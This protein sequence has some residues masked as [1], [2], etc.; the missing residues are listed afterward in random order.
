MGIFDILKAKGPNSEN[1]S[2]NSKYK[3][4]N[5]KAKDGSYQS[6]MAVIE[7]LIGDRDNN[8][9]EILLWIVQN[10][11]S[12]STDVRKLNE[13]A[14]AASALGKTGG[15]LALHALESVKDMPGLVSEVNHAIAEIREKQDS[16]A[17]FEGL[18]TT[19]VPTLTVL[20]EKK[21]ECGVEYA[22]KLLDSSDILTVVTAARYLGV[23][24]YQPA[25]D[26]LIRLVE[27]SEYIDIQHTAAVAL[28]RIGG[29]KAKA[30]LLSALNNKSEWA[31]AGAVKGLA[32][33]WADGERDVVEQIAGKRSGPICSRDSEDERKAQFD[34]INTMLLS[35]ATIPAVAISGAE[36]IEADKSRVTYK[37]KCEACGYVSPNQRTT[38]VPCRGKMMAYFHCPQCKSGQNIVIEG[39]K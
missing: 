16:E 22:M 10:G 12:N 29:S 14:A 31:V 19:P 2:A 9:I 17:L 34:A 27:K 35:A 39:P 37:E 4:L 24:R 20:T 8:A 5:K 13:R 21:D 33:M 28:G 32:F 3:D 38:A 6:R 36:I 1:K 25:T 30:A 23:V 11:N 18:K 7:A 15:E 26:K